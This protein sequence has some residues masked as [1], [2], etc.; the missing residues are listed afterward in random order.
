VPKVEQEIATE[1]IIIKQPATYTT[2][3]VQ[4]ESPIQ[5]NANVFEP[6]TLKIAKQSNTLKMALP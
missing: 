1:P 3:M 2:M 4:T 6:K 5:E